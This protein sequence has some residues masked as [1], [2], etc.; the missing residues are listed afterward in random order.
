MRLEFFYHFSIM[1]WTIWVPAD[2]RSHR[3]M[4]YPSQALWSTL[5]ERDRQQWKL[6]AKRMVKAMEAAPEKT[7]AAEAKRAAE[8]KR[9][10]AQLARTETSKYNLIDIAAH[11]QVLSNFFANAAQQLSEYRV[12]V[13][14]TLIANATF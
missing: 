4:F 11:F 6:R 10:E 3:C 12:S 14:F 2:Q 5:P 8:L 1:P 13:F 9:A 7:A